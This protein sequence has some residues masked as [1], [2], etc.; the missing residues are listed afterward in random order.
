MRCVLAWDLPVLQYAVTGLFKQ[1]SL[2]RA[3]STVCTQQNPA[4]YAFHKQ[5]RASTMRCEQLV[6]LVASWRHRTANKVSV[7]HD[8]V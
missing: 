1:L 4:V 7:G 5:Q 6:E 3:A 8:P 2:N